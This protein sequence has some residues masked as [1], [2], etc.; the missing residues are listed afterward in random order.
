M[1]PVHEFTHGVIWLHLGAELGEWPSSS[2][3]E[4]MSDVMAAMVDRTG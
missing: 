1:S 2:L 4:G 3:N